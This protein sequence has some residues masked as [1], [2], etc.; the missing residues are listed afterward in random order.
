MP[1]VWSQAF[2]GGA[3]LTTRGGDFDLWLGQDLSIGSLG[4]TADGATLYL[5]ERLTFQMQT[6]EAV[7]VLAA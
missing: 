4:H 3:V 2:D 6:S 1:V 5:Q 7:V